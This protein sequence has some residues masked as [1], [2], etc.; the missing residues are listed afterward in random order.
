MERAGAALFKPRKKA[1]LYLRVSTRNQLQGDYDPEGQSI[2][3]QR[4]ETTRKLDAEFSADVVA[5][6][7]DPGKTAT[8]TKGRDDFQEMMAYVREHPEVDYIGVFNRARLFRNEFDAA[9]ARKELAKLGVAI[10]SVLDYTEASPI[11]DLV[12]SV[13]DAVNA[14]QSRAQGADIARKMLGKVERGGSCARAS[15]GYLNVREKLDDGRELRTIGVDPERKDLVILAFEMFA[16]GKYTYDTGLQAI[17]DAG[18]RTRPTKAYPAGKPLS[19][20]KFAQM[21]KDRT[22]IGE[23]LWKGQWFPAGRH[24]PLVERALFDQVQEVIELHGGGDG[25]RPRT[26]FHHLKGEVWCPRC[27]QRYYYIP[28]KSKTGDLHFYFVCAGRWTGNGCTMPYFRAVDM[29]RAVEDAYAR[30]AL[31]AAL[32]QEIEDAM[33]A[34]LMIS[35]ERDGMMREQ[36]LK[37][38]DGIERNI[39]GLLR[40]IGDPEWPQDNI[41]SRINEARAEQ[42]RLRRKAAKLDRPNIDGGVV[43]MRTLLQLLSRPRDLYEISS[44]RGRK[45]LNQIVF[46]R[47]YVDENDGAPRV[48]GDQLTPEVRPLVEVHRA[49]LTGQN[50]FGAVAENDGA[51]EATPTALL[52]SA[53]VGAGSNNGQMVEPRGLEPLTPALQRQCSAN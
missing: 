47:L 46:T 11:G 27:N 39:N 40:L 34:A 22:Y 37:E 19:R 6:F 51:D 8:T 15:I 3:T 17:T 31:P 16:T 52:A 30:V 5:E 36:L 33:D 25:T 9:I 45:L 2:P 28:G 48:T 18:L 44:E 14:Y 12:A 29:E 26:H 13:I 10:V 23:V 50:D 41:K 38:L 1:I 20:K 43:V 21:L 42:D 35:G 4:G 53:L 24:E 32:R 49:R 7:I